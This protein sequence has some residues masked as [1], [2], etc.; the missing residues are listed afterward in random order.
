MP[1]PADDSFR[2]E[3]LDQRLISP[4]TKNLAQEMHRRGTKAARD[5]GFK[6]AQSGNSAGYLSQLFDFHEKLVDEWAEKLYAAYCEAWKQQNRTISP[7]F[8]R[9]VRDQPLAELI[10]A[11]KSSLLEQVRSRGIQISEK[12]NATALEE[13]GRKMDSLA[14]R[15]NCK[16]EGDAAACE[17]RFSKDRSMAN[18][19]VVK[20]GRARKLPTEFVRFAGK[21]WLDAK[22]QRSRS[23]VGHEQLEQIASHLDGQGY[24][25]PA[26]YLEKRFAE[27]LKSFNSRHSNSKRGVIK[28]WSRL[29]SSADKDHL[30]GMRRLLSRCAETSSSNSV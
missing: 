28:T 29:V 15:W 30:R 23:P 27:E 7:E 5:I 22:R 6:N 26:D 12:P 2:W 25:P 14:T 11:R 24:V 17:Y 13:W 10:A 9:A 21:L 20:V 16:L 19:G 4:K 3:D 18:G 1:A 8:I